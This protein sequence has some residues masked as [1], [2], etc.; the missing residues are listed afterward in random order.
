M[1]LFSS[2][3]I[4]N[5]L[6]TVGIAVLTYLAN[7]HIIPFLAIGKRKQFAEY[8]ATIADEVIDDLRA[9]YPNKAWLTKLDE[10]VETLVLICDIESEIAR[11][12]INAS[13]ARTTGK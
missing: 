10:A 7:R 9:K 8:I 13:A 11:R 5:L 1:E 3:P 2:N 4:I 12:A 6:S